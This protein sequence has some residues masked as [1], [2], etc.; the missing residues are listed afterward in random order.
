MDSEPE[1]KARTKIPEGHLK[2]RQDTG[3]PTDS[4]FLEQF[5]VDDSD[6][7]ITTDA[8]GPIEDNHSL[9]AGPR[10]T[11]ALLLMHDFQLSRSSFIALG[12]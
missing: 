10:G 7:F 3:Y 11:L 5:T 6:A 9:K 12:F 4:S 1:L 2:A 8:G